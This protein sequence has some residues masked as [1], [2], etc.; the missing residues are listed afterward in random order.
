MSNGNLLKVFS[1]LHPTLSS[2]TSSSTSG[3]GP[4]YFEI[5]LDIHRFSY[6]AR[7]GLDA[8]R[9]RLK[10]GIL[11]LGLTIQ[12]QKPEELPE[13]VLCCVRLNKIDFVDRGQ[14][15]TL[16]RVEDNEQPSQSGIRGLLTDA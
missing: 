15:P 16:M 4:N 7:K 10:E 13:T 11:D 9:E 8:F 2:F 12:A 6:I 14:I 5:D 1:D 3:Q